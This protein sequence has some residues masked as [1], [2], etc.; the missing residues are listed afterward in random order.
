MFTTYLMIGVAVQIATTLARFVNGIVNIKD[1]GV[2][3]ADPYG[4][5]A[6][7]ITLLLGGLVNVL[8]WPLTIIC[9][10]YMYL[11]NKA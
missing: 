9:E 7:I 2:V 3:F 5:V 8:L 6:F 1:L 10:L 4:T 11:N